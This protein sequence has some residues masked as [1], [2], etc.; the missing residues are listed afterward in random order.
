MSR[1]RVPVYGSSFDTSVLVLRSNVNPRPGAE[2]RLVLPKEG[3]AFLDAL[4]VESSGA[5][6]RARFADE[7]T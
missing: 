1:S 3:Q 7:A 2:Q 5:Y 6:V 4:P